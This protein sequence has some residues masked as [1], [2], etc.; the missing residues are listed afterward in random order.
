MSAEDDEALSRQI[1]R[2]RDIM[3]AL[4]DPVR[5]CPWDQQ[6]NFASIAPYTIEEAYEVADAIQ[7]ADMDDL[8]G[9]LGDLLLQVVYHSRMAEEDGHFRLTDVVRR[10][11]DKMVAR[12]PHVF[13]QDIVADAEA[14]T[15]N[16]EDMKAAERGDAGTLSGVALALPALMRAEKLQKRAARVGFDWPDPVGPRAKIHEELAELDAAGSDEERLAEGGD[17]LFA[18]VNY[19]RHLGID[20]EAALRDTNARFT[21]RFEH[22]ETAA[23]RPLADHSLEEI[24]TLWVQAKAEESRTKL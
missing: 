6:Q 19:L 1:V 9:E 4:R 2:L 17:L 22:V 16:W 24:E 13:G 14:Q 11:A 23:T 20:P 8:A 21:R 15:R 12:H 18:V 7:R 10:I 5:G 3:A